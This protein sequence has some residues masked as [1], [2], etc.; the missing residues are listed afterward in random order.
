MSS[1][2][3]LRLK[4]ILFI[5]S[6]F[7]CSS[8][9]AQIPSELIYQTP[10]NIPA[11]QLATIQG[12]QKTSTALKSINTRIYITYINTKATLSKPGEWSRAYRIAP[13]ETEVRFTFNNQNYFGNGT[14]TF[15]AEPTQHYQIKT[16]QPNINPNQEPILFWIENTKNE[17]AVTSKQQIHISITSKTFYYLPVIL[18]K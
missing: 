4:S 16:N 10:K 7:N 13:G 9:L 6:F 11:N 2:K 15:E 8:I 3:Y 1:I 17:E 14:I 12:P 18:S 5:T